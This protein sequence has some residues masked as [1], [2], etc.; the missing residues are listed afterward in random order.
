MALL[1]KC[2]HLPDITRAEIVDKSKANNLAKALVMVQA[3][4]MLL[5]VIERLIV[6]FPVTLLKVNTIAHVYVLVALL[7]DIAS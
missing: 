2:S 5:Q 6:R 4:R 7:L 3:L 1:A